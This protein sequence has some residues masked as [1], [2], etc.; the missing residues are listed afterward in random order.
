[1]SDTDPCWIHH[2]KIRNYVE[3]SEADFKV[4]SI[5]SFMDT[6]Y[7]TYLAEK[8]KQGPTIIFYPTYIVEAKNFEEHVRLIIEI[9]TDEKGSLY[10]KRREFFY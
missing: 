4:V 10:L 7:A 1:M 5:H 8:E 3:K 9:K 2:E 6:R